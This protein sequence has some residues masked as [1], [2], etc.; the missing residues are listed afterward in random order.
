MSNAL[1]RR[2]SSKQ[3]LQNLMRYVVDV[4]LFLMLVSVCFRST[5]TER[6]SS[7]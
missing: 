7:G 4:S 5:Q 6:R 1:L 3:G 2:N